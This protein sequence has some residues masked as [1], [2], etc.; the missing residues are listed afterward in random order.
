MTHQPH[1][2]S[3][4]GLAKKYLDQLPSD[5]ISRRYLAGESYQPSWTSRLKFFLS[6]DSILSELNSFYP[7]QPIVK[8]TYEMYQEQKSNY[9]SIAIG[10]SAV[11]M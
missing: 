8:R 7:H 6:T 4:L 3:N 9:K 5:D 11:S 10:V 1:V 2:L